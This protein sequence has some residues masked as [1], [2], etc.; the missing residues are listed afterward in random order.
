MNIRC[1]NTLYI[2]REDLKKFSFEKR[3]EGSYW[4]DIKPVFVIHLIVIDKAITKEQ[5]R[6]SEVYPE[7]I[8]IKKLHKSMLIYEN[9][10]REGKSN[11]KGKRR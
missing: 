2:F 3:K 6:A 10:T 5:F 1:L 4:I 11:P 9:K 8:K 7:V